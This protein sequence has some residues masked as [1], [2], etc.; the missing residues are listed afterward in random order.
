VPIGRGL[1]AVLATRCERAGCGARWVDG[2]GSD[3]R[4]WP[5]G[6]STGCRFICGCPR[7]RGEAGAVAFP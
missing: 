1:G 6:K 3:E 2:T 7:P 4:R 5:A